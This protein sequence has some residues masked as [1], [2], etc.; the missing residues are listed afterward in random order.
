MCAFDLSIAEDGAALF[1]AALA[2][3]EIAGLAER[4]ESAIDRRPGRRLPN[5]ASAGYLL[6]PDG[7][8]VSN[9]L[10][11]AEQLRQ[12]KRENERLRLERD[13]LKKAVG[14]FSQTPPRL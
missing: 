7:P 3:D 14:I 9:T 12:L 8:I 13:I 4:L 5:D 1:P 11:E 10:P 6:A 2:A